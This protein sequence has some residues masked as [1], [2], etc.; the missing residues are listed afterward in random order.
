MDRDGILGPDAPALI[1]AN[2]YRFRSGEYI[3][4]PTV[5]SLCLLWVTHGSGEIRSANQTLVPGPREVLI[6]PWRHEVEYFPDHA[7]PL[8]IGTVHLVPHYETSVPVIAG[9]GLSEA[10][11]FF[12]DPHRHDSPRMPQHPLLIDQAPQV[13]SLIDLGR[14]AI[15]VFLQGRTDERALRSLGELL[16]AE[17]AQV[18]REAEAPKLPGRLVEMMGFMRSYLDRPLTLADIARSGLCSQATAQRLFR[19]HTG[20]SVMSWLTRERL[21][22]ASILLTTTGLNVTQ[23]AA[24]VGY[25]DPLYFSRV[26]SRAYGLSPSRYARSLVEQGGTPS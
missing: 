5:E 15:S 4:H 14:Y 3:H 25:T 7:N 18:S 8:H 22:Q 24:Y 10:D 21:T 26:F 13:Q 9:V 17:V 1:G 23:V 19:T 2:T 6:L 11:P 12:G 16:C 20:Q